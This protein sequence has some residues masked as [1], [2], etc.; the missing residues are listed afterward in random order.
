MLL[1]LL[2]VHAIFI[3]A[4]QLRQTTNWL[5]V[6]VVVVFVPVYGNSMRDKPNNNHSNNSQPPNACGECKHD[7]VGGSDGDIVVVVYCC[8]CC[9]PLQLESGQQLSSFGVHALPLSLLMNVFMH[10]I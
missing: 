4:L 6:V 9:C 1:L 3:I 2:L 7:G 10:T 5:H 8:C